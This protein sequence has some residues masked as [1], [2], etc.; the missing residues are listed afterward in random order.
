MSQSR[1]RAGARE[2]IEIAAVVSLAVLPSIGGPWF[3]FGVALACLVLRPAFGRGLG[4]LLL[5]LAVLPLAALVPPWGC[6]PWAAALPGP[7]SSLTPQPFALLAAWPGYLAGL[8]YLWWI[9]GRSRDGFVEARQSGVLFLAIVGSLLLAA[10]R[11]ESGAW[12]GPWAG[13]FEAVFGTRNQAG[14]YAAVAVA[15]CAMKVVFSENAQRR[16]LWALGGA[17]CSAPLMTLGSR[18]AIGA[19][20]VGCAA[21]WLLPA[22]RSQRRDRRWQRV[23]AGC[24]VAFLAGSLVVILF[25]AAPIVARFGEAGVSGAGVRMAIQRDAWG[26]LAAFPLT[27]IGLGNF[28]VVFPFFRSVS[29]SPTRAFHPESDWLWL[30]CEAGAV[31]G[32]LAWAVVAVL[33]ARLWKL[34]RM[35]P[36]EAAVGFAALAAAAAHGLL[37][38]PAHCASVFVLTCAF[39]GTGEPGRRDGTRL[40]AWTVALGL[41]LTSLVAMHWTRIP[42][43]DVIR[44]D[45]PMLIP[46][47]ALTRQWLD[48]HPLDYEVLEWEVH[49]AIQAGDGLLATALMERLFLLEPFSTEP[50][51]RV[52]Q[53]LT[54][55][56]DARRALFPARVILERTP[57]AKRWERLEQLLR[58]SASLPE[59]RAGILSLPPATAACQA[60]RIAAMGADVPPPER[61]LFIELASRPG[62]PGFPETLAVTALHMASE[63]ELAR[64]DTIPSLA[65]PALAIR[66]RRLAESGDFESACRL[67]VTA[68]G[69]SD[70]Q[71]QASPET[72]ATVRLALQE[73]RAGNP[74]RARS[75]L[76]VA[77]ARHASSRELWYLLGRAEWQLGSPERGW[78]AFEKYL[79]L[80]QTG[81]HGD[82]EGR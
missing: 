58:T 75:L 62:D 35:R 8:A 40:A 20:A 72:P 34:A 45:R 37:D 81:S 21:G 59:L 67:A 39:A 79:G 32:I 60:V 25:P 10:G 3:A 49:R 66:A 31:A 42:R 76:H 51:T 50:P 56:G 61:F 17:A 16:W 36:G 64:A 70:A 33:A 41:A 15:A 26:L 38:V 18:G 11:W 5:C 68:P 77:E 7:A 63:G 14:G 23:L 24:L 57:A 43:P 4:I 12:R 53:A 22:M 73:M 74:E 2:A 78:K 52:F 55:R 28:D 54:A 82:H 13:V 65:G 19:A 69:L 30:S 46:A 44:P 71:I 48:F 47:Q 1:Q 80:E 6:L 29:A 9:C 27:G